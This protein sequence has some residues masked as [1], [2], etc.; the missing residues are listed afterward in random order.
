MSEEHQVQQY[1]Q[2]ESRV[3]PFRVRLPP[4]PCLARGGIAIGPGHA[5]LRASSSSSIQSQAG[6]KPPS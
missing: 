6:Y 2:E 5:E 3:P 1:V 4:W